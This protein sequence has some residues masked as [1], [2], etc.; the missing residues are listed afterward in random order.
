MCER[1]YSFEQSTLLF[2]LHTGFYLEK[3][4]HEMNDQEMSFRSMQTLIC[5]IIELQS[6]LCHRNLNPLADS[7]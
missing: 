5:Q 1:Y 4:T 7:F 3:S 2:L 6:I